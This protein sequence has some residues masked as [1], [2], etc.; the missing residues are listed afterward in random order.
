MYITVDDII[1]LYQMR[2]SVNLFSVCTFYSV[3]SLQSAFCTEW[4]KIVLLFFSV[5]RGTPTDF[6]EGDSEVGAD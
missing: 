4:T 6:H 2:N 3:S 5:T 1:V